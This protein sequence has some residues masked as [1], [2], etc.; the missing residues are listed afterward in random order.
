MGNE[1]AEN[2][3]YWKEAGGEL[4]SK[5]YYIYICMMIYR[6]KCVCLRGGAA[7]L[8]EQIGTEG[9]IR[10]KNQKMFW[11]QQKYCPRQNIYFLQKLESYYYETF[12]LHLHHIIKHIRYN[13]RLSEFQFKISQTVLKCLQH[14]FRNKTNKIQSNSFMHYF[15]N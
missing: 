12:V 14:R 3:R 2:Q 8:K 4:G 6:I 7:L 15:K 11:L 1:H 5:V 9:M 13:Q 10:R